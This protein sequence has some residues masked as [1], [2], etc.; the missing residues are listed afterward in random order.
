MASY[1]VLNPIL[2]AQLRRRGVRLV[3]FDVHFALLRLLELASGHF[4]NDVELTTLISKMV[5]VE[6]S[7]IILQSD[8][9]P[10]VS[11]L[12]KD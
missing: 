5:Q 6:S 1:L 7:Q 4:L 3:F 2:V 8:K 11:S 10:E 12:K 9:C